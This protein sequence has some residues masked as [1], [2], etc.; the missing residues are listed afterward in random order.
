MPIFGGDPRSIF[1]HM[2]YQSNIWYDALLIPVMFIALMRQFDDNES[3]Y[4]PFP[5]IAVEIIRICLNTGHTQGNIPVTIAYLVFD[6]IA[7]VL[8]FICIFLKK[9]NT[10]FYNLIMMGYACL[11]ILQFFIILPTFRSFKYYKTGYYQFGR[12]HLQA[13][14]NGDDELRLMDVEQS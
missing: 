2:V 14:Q 1:V 6:I 8:D 11:H 13:E 5:F 4:F 10:H 3:F 7:I 9:N 12:G